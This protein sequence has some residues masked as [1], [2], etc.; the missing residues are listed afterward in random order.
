M[1]ALIRT[2]TVSHPRSGERIGCR[3]Q[4]CIPN[5]NARKMKKSYGGKVE[6][7]ATNEMVPSFRG[8]FLIAES[9]DYASAESITK[10]EM[11]RFMGRLVWLGYT[12][13]EVI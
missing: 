9:S 11:T 8:T 4:A 5:L 3:L 12:E 2:K 6:F 10:P 7:Y 13:F 1:K